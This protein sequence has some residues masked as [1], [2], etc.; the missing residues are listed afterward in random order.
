MH[1]LLTRTRVIRKPAYQARPVLP[2]S[3]ELAPV[4]DAAAMVGPF[5][6]L[7]RI[8]KS[9]IGEWLTGFDSRLLRRV[10]IHVVPPGTPPVSPV[11]RNLSRVGRLRWIAGR[12]TPEEN[13]DA[14]EAVTG[15]ALLQLLPERPRWSQVRF[16]LLDLAKELHTAARDGTLPEVLALDRVWI[17][18]DGRAKLLDFP[19]PGL[20]KEGEPEAVSEN[21]N[22][23]PALEPGRGIVPFL[24]QVA[25]AALEGRAPSEA[26]IRAGSPDDSPVPSGNLPGGTTLTA[27]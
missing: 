20:G 23:P 1:D 24:N 5:H 8:E 27:F 14:F 11:L 22:L 6:L 19:A 2:P 4:T 3:L 21:P 12:R 7:E 25:W 17:T 15:R 10:W 18:T 9:P 16:W 26:Q 13:W